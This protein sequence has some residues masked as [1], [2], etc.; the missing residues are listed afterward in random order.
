MRLTASVFQLLMALFLASC[1]EMGISATSNAPG[2]SFQGSCRGEFAKG[3]QQL[4]RFK[5]EPNFL[6]TFAA[7]QMDI[8]RTNDTRTVFVV[9]KSADCG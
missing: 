2:I 4:D 3:S 8:F 7:S 5:Y 1:T 9:E 6:R